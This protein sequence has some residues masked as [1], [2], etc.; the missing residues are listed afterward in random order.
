MAARLLLT[1]KLL[2]NFF[3]LQEII[4]KY[5]ELIK[6]LP[7]VFK[8]LNISDQTEENEEREEDEMKA[9]RL[10][11]PVSPSKVRLRLERDFD[12]TS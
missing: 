12:H 5:T 9:F 1:H 4:T 2:L 7:H 3:G 11:A 8:R 6:C 10:S